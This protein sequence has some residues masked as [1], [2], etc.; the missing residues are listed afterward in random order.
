MVLLFGYKF[1]DRT[2]FITEIELE[3]VK[4]VFVEQAFVNYRIKPWLNL[5]GG[6]MLIP[7][8]IV[9]EYHEPTSYNGVERPNVDKYIVPSTWREIGLGFTGQIQQSGIGYQLYLVNGFLGSDDG[10][11]KFSGSSLFRSGRQKGAESVLTRPNLAFRVNYSGIPGLATGFSGYFGKSQ[12][13]I[14][15]G[16][17]TADPSLMA[18]ADSSLVGIRMIGIDARYTIS[19]ISWRGQFISGSVSNT[20]Q[21]NQFH[22]ADLGMGFIGYYAELS[23]DLLHTFNVGDDQLIP[24]IRYENY[25]THRAVDTSVPQNTAFNRSDVTFGLGW[26]PN[27]GVIYKLDYQIFSNESTTISK[28]QFNA[29]IGIWF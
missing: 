7:M 22:N 21:Y 8:G 27:S 25:D 6:L 3:H 17:N 15:D 20:D 16:I 13:T 9:N 12:S 18:S 5:R 11:A 23:Y 1:D 19:G 10:S 4:E 29:G 24:F 26:K 28:Q 14:L 2:T